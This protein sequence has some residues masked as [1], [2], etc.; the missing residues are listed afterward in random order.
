MSVVARDRLSAPYGVRSAASRRA[1][2]RR[3]DR[4]RLALQVA[5]ACRRLGL[6][7]LCTRRYTPRTNGKVER[8]IKTTLLEWAY[9][10]V[11][12]HSDKRRAALR[13]WL[14]H[15][16]WHRRHTSLAGRPPITRVLAA[17]NLASFTA[18]ARGWSICAA[19]N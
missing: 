13:P 1:R 8:F 4:Q 16:N 18:G 19:C 2:R 5:A 11:Y 9:A 15:Y 10:R 17:D 3:D 14:H 12:R 7:H 6:R